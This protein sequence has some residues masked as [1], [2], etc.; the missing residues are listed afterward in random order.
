[1]KIDSFHENHL[2]VKFDLKNVYEKFQM[3]SE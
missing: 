3:S 1:M 2:V